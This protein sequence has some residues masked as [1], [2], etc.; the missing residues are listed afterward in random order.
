MKKNILTGQQ[1]GLLGGPLYTTYKVLG[2]IS[3]AKD[4]SGKAI[5]W[6][7]TNDADFNEINHIEYIDKEGELQTLKWDIDTK[8]YSCGY[9]EIDKKLVE[10]LN[11]FFSTIHQTEYTENLKKEVLESYKPGSTLGEASISLAQKLFS[12]YNLK[13]FDPGEVE[14]RGFSKDILLK[15]AEIGKDNEQCNLF[16]LDRKKRLAVFKK[17]KNFYLRDGNKIEIADYD[18]LPNVKTRN[19]CQDAF[20][21]THTYIAGPGEI[22][23]I[24]ELG[25]YYEAHKIIKS[26][27]QGRMSIDLIEPRINRLIKK[28]GISFSEI[29]SKTIE[30]VL[31]EELVKHSGFDKKKISDNL[32]KSMDILIRSYEQEGIETAKLR[33][34]IMSETKKLIGEKRKIIKVDFENKQ[35]NIKNIFN[36]LKPFGKRQ[37]RIFNIFYY[38]NLYGGFEFIDF[39]YKNHDFNKQYL[40]V[41]NG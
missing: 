40:E 39:L 11:V 20:F 36:N 32:N 14:F 19:L 28:T 31:K 9:I 35:N 41:V 10:I 8:G 7:E 2:A 34:I 33:K 15:E 13:I 37:E 24:K 16:C 30:Q 4:I 1:I 25:K 23:Y 27:I 29:E 3:F 26:N 17:N 21:N 12:K 5:Y 6:L 38:M 18:L 22:K